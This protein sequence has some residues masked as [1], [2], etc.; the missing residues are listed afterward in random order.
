[1][2][3]IKRAKERCGVDLVFDDLIAI[4][5]LIKAGESILLKKRPGADSET[6][7]VNYKGHAL[8]AVFKEN[9]VVTFL[10]NGPS[11]RHETNKHYLNSRSRRRS[12]VLSV[13]YRKRKA[14]LG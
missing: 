12:R 9:V 10:A 7:L 5:D 13:G 2:H 3:P 11:K 1:M 14:A 8:K 6:H 4:A